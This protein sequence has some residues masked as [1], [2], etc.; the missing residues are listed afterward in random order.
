MAIYVLSPLNGFYSVLG[1]LPIHVAM[2]ICLAIMLNKS[3]E[4]SEKFK[5]F[6]IASLCGHTFIA[7]TMTLGLF[8]VKLFNFKTILIFP[9]MG[10]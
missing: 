5:T 1:S 10:I 2:V 4:L 9:A 3:P 8:T 7:G 6:G